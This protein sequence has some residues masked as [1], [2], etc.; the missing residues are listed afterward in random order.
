MSCFSCRF[1]KSRVPNTK[2]FALLMQTQ[3]G[4]QR[5]QKVVEEK[6]EGL[7]SCKDWW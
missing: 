2:H 1:E 4:C 6:K 7:K 3:D 5:E